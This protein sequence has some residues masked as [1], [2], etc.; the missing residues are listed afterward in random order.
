[1][2]NIIGVAVLE[3]QCTMRH[4]YF[5]RTNYSYWKCKMKVYI[6]SIDYAI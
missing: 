6:Q 1:M 3:G 4:P 2:S 5:D